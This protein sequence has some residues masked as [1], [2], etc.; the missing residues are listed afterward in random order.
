MRT[1]CQHGGMR[2]CVR[3]RSFAQIRTK[4]G[5]MEGGTALAMHGAMLISA[6]SVVAAA[7]ALF[8]LVQLVLALRIRATV[9]VLSE[10]DAPTPSAWPR[11]SVIVPARNEAHG[12]E[13]AL[14]SKLACGYPNL[15]VV[16]VDD[17]STDGTGTIAARLASTD[18]RL[19][20]TR[21]DDL[22]PGWL[23]KLN[24]LSVGVASASGDWLLL[25]DADVHVTKGT[26]ERAIAHA[27]AHEVD[28]IA[29]L[30]RMH[31]VE[32][33]L[34]A[35]VTGMIRTTAL[36]GRTWSA[37]DDASKIGVG[38]GAFNLVR[39][40]ALERS[41]GLAYLRMEMADDVALGAM[42]KASGARCRFFAARD[43]VH[44]VFAERLGVLSRG[45]EK[46]GGLLGFSLLRTLAVACAWLAIDV[47]VPFVALATQ[48]PLA[49][50]L[51]AAQ[52]VL[53]TAMHVVLARHFR[54]PMRGALL[55][56]IGTIVGI[57][58]LARSGALA[59]WRGAIVWRGTSYGRAEIEA[60]RR[61]LSGQV[62]LDAE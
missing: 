27:E 16:V 52:L 32:P 31:A 51:G 37:N 24:A 9:P 43:A 47:A 57:A 4:A 45:V 38:V 28:F 50:A 8:A 61:W 13:A 62:R 2:A 35:C 12:I 26:I 15:E 39:R 17:R 34:D 7:C 18:A 25:S 22:P 40:S 19:T 1:D 23:G 6:L 33:I 10:I 49:A 46:G 20:V 42:L 58:L 36:V 54:L 48:S 41:R 29:M 60:G 11:L 30:P 14:A 3:S 44:I 59:W 53:L 56:P 21:V 55:W 5:P